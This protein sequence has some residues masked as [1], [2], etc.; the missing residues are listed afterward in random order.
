ML[1]LHYNYTTLDLELEELRWETISKVTEKRQRNR[2]KRNRKKETDSPKPFVPP[3][4]LTP[5]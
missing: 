5:S 4:A 3:V 2:K 1:Q